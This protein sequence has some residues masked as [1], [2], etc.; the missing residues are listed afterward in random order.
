MRVQLPSQGQEPLCYTNIIT[1]F[2]PL[3]QRPLMAST[4]QTLADGGLH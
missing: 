1:V 4:G 3:Q 2:K